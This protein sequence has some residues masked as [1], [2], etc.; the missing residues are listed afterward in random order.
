MARY[1]NFDSDLI[2]FSH[3]LNFLKQ[4]LSE[5]VGGHVLDEPLNIEFDK[6]D[7]KVKF[8]GLELGEYEKQL[9]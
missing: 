8:N 9:K 6:L 2:G 7:G 4:G 3:V 1:L 5:I